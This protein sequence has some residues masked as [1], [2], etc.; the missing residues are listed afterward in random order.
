[1]QASPAL[2][3]MLEG[4]GVKVPAGGVTVGDYNVAEALR[5]G[6]GIW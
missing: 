6:Q 3:T 5:K 2:V 1:V 4:N